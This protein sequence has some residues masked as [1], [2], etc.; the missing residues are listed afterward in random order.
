MYCEEHERLRD[1][2]LEAV[3]KNFKA[4]LTV[5]DNKSEAWREAT[6]ETQEACIL[7]LEDLNAHMRE[8]GC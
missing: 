5:A 2:Y 3:H 1:L 8:H 6:K 4:S 7:A